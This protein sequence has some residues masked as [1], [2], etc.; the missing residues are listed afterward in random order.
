MCERNK[1]HTVYFKD[2]A[3]CFTYY[4]VSHSIRKY[5]L[6][7]MLGLQLKVKKNSWARKTI[8]HPTTTSLITNTE[9]VGVFII[10]GRTLTLPLQC[11]RMQLPLCITCVCT[12]VPG[13]SQ[14]FYHFSVELKFYNILTWSWTIR[15]ER[16]LITISTNGNHV[17]Y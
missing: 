5:S 13:T 11:D 9:C 12:C 3:V 2:K 7:A 16:W 10:A 17:W 14:G 8:P 15:R 6:Q 4:R 1:L